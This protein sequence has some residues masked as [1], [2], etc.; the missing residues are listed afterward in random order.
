LYDHTPH[1]YDG[2]TASF[3]P[4]GKKLVTANYGEGGVRAWDNHLGREVQKDPGHTCRIWDVE[5]GKLLIKLEGHSRRVSSAV[6]FSDGKKVITRGSDQT[7]RIWDAES[8]KEL[9]MIK[10]DRPFNSF[11][12]AFSAD[13]K[14]LATF[15]GPTT[16]IWNLEL[17]LAPP[18]P[19]VRDF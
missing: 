4:D 6:F 7:I 14:R 15:D 3:S 9:Q 18:L 19:R 17:L 2:F 13:G 16:R 12:P 1:T 11:P 8:G 10:I 5:S